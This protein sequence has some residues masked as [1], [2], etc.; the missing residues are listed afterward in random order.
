MDMMILRH[1]H[2]RVR[3]V[4]VQKKA[5][6]HVIDVIVAVQMQRY[7]LGMQQTSVMVVPG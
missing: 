4:A 7:V 2:S 6:M 5:D 3:Y 1:V